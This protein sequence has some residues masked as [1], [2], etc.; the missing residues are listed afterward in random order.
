MLAPGALLKKLSFYQL[1]NLD[2]RARWRRP[3][4][5]LRERCSK[6]SAFISF[7]VL[8]TE[9]DGSASNACSKALLKRLSF[10]QPFSLDDRI[11]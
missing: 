10:N 4:C 2:D 7:L 5:M 6:N 11:L 1:F 3:Q 8:I 9:F